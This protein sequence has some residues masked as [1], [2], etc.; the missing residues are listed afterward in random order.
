MQNTIKALLAKAIKPKKVKFLI[1]H[2]TEDLAKA[3]TGK[4][5]T[6]ICQS[7]AKPLP[8]TLSQIEALDAE[9]IT[10]LETMIELRRRKKELVKKES[11]YINLL[12]K[13]NNNSI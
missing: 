12:K 1:V 8:F 13:I 5:Y 7:P 4:N 3:T 2:S 11:A 10:E 6:I 9:Q